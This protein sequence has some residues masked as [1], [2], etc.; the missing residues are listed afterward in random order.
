MVLSPTSGL[1]RLLLAIIIISTVSYLT[2]NIVSFA[3]ARW[4]TYRDV[5]VRFGLWTVCDTT[6]SG[7]CNQWSD[8]QYKTAN[9]NGTFNGDKPG[10][11]LVY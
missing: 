8:S 4:I 1:G 7:L 10:F 3:G 6:A 2:L 5:P 9:T 11:H